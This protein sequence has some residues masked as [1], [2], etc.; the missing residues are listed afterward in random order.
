MCICVVHP[1]ASVAAVSLCYS[2]CPAGTQVKAVRVYQ[3]RIHQFW[4]DYQEEIQEQVPGTTIE[5]FKYARS[6]VRC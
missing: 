5:D 4:E 1:A 6:L 3:Q 2:C